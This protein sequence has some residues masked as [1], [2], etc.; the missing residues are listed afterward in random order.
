MP[1]IGQLYDL[2]NFKKFMDSANKPMF[3]DSDAGIVL[4]KNLTA[5]NPKIFEKKYPELAFINSGIQVDNTGGYARRI[6]SLRLIDRGDFADAG[7]INSD[8]GKISLA[9][10]DTYLKV[11]VKEAYSIWTDDDIKEAKLQNINLPERYIATHNKVYLQKIDEIGFIG[12]NGQA[13]LL[14]YKGFA[15]T[16]AVDKIENETPQQMYDEIATLITEQR[17]AVNNTPEYSCNRVVMP[18]RVM[19]K[20]SATILN[21]AGGSKSVLK[22][23]KDNFPDVEFLSTFRAENV[24]GTSRVVA[25]SVSEDAMKMRIP[26]RLTIGEIIRI[27]SF[28]FRI[29]SKFRIAGLDVLESSSARI[30]VGL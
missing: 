1:K 18:I 21:S 15:V 29:D 4:A 9:A 11:F 22:A 3:K 6:Q 23:L 7:D 10:E 26:L 16:T 20:L 2:D 30:L 25:F 8:K 27:S 14:N 19:N 12:H 13:G 28:A 17:N 5:I 24:D